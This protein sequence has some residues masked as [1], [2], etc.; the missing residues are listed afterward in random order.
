MCDDSSMVSSS[1]VRAVLF[2]LALS[3]AACSTGDPPLTPEPRVAAPAPVD[4]LLSVPSPPEWRPGDR[5]TYDLTSGNDRGAKTMEVIEVRE[6]ANVP[7]YVVRLGDID[8]Y[9]TR[10]LNWAAATRDSKVEARMTPPHQGFVWPLEVGKRWTYQGVWQDENS[11]RD[12]SDRF[13]VVAVETVEVLAGRFE[14]LK[15]VRE[16]STPGSD[17]YWFAPAVRSY[18]RWAG[19]RGDVQFEERLREYRPAP[20][21]TPER[22][23]PGPSSK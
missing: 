2:A 7:Y 19:R 6:I 13:A 5:W 1:R 20:R 17:E 9:Y 11:R 14:A 8:H 16:G 18:V 4:R 10:N 15:I 12:V 3:S 23:V 22:N 21:L